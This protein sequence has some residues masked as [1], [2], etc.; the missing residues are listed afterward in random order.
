MAHDVLHDCPVCHK[1]LH[2][3]KLHC[4]ACGTSIEG[5]F[6][7]ERLLALTPEQR[8]FVLSFLRNRGNIREMEKEL[9]I[10]YPTVRARLDQILAALG[11]EANPGKEKPARKEVLEMLAQGEI[12]QEQA[13]D[14]LKKP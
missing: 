5:D 7:A 3:T 9:G 6:Q 10:S 4:P 14:M 1:P 11:L 8:S 2:I 13:L 12:T